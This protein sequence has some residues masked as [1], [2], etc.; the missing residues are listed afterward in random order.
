MNYWKLEV[1]NEPRTPNPELRTMN[2]WQLTTGN[3]QLAT[4][5][6]QPTT[7]NCLLHL[8][9]VLYKF[10]LFYAKQ[11]QF[12]ECSNK[13]KHCYN[14]GLCQHTPPQPLQKQSQTNPIKPKTN[15]IQTQF[16]PKY[17]E[18]KPNQTQFQTQPLL[19]HRARPKFSKFHAKIV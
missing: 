15:P 5:N 9:R 16:Q 2:Y 4:D 6:W 3:R 17:A 12:T 18:N 8:S 13:R 19:I 11:T 1:N 10:T 14:N 7:G